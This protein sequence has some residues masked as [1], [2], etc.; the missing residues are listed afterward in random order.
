MKKRF[1]A[2]VLGTVMTASLIAGC[3]AKS[4]GS[5]SGNAAAGGTSA[6]AEEKQMVEGGDFIKGVSNRIDV[7]PETQYLNIVHIHVNPLKVYLPQ[8]YMPLRLH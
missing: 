5:S 7:C 8:Q 2:L 1:L 6:A 3:G 4:S